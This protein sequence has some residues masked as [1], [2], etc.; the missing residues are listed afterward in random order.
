MMLVV[1]ETEEETIE[2]YYDLDKGPFPFKEGEKASLTIQGR[3][4]VG[5]EAVREESLD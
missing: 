5:Y 1:L 4:L 2:V 3:F